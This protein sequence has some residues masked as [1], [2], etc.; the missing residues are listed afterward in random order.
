MQL[1][2]TQDAID[3]RDII[4][5]IEELREQSNAS[6][7]AVGF[8]MPGYMPDSVDLYDSPEEAGAALA[9]TMR[10]HAAELEDVDDI[11]G[12]EA[13]LSAQLDEWADALDADNAGEWGN[14]IGQYHYFINDRGQQIDSDDLDELKTLEALAAECEG[15]GDWE[16]GAT[17]IHEDY[18]TSYIEELI[19]DCYELPKE[20]TSGEWPY[21]HITIDYEAAAQEAKA[22]YIEVDYDGVTYLMHA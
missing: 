21:R 8:N 3:S 6:R 14:T 5:R 15:Y 18:F 10:Q 16:H 1:D 2:N 19:D 13:A 12:D 11:D 4:E 22:D 7:W 9:E 17:L 20:L